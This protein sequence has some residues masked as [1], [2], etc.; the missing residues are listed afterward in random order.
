[1]T[2]LTI[3]RTELIQ[4]AS[5][6]GIK[7]PRTIPGQR[8]PLNP[9]GRMM[10]RFER[11]GAS[12]IG[13]ALERLRRSLFRGLTDG[14]VHELVN[15]LN[16]SQ[17]TQPFQDA[18]M[19]LVEEWALAGANF[20]QAVVNNQILGVTS[21]TKQTTGIDWDLVNDEAAEWAMRYAALLVTDI[22]G[23][24]R[25]R[26]Q[27]EVAAFILTSETIGELSRRIQAS[28]I[29]GESRADMIA[30]TEVTQAF[31]QGNMIAWLG[32]GVVQRRRWNTNNDEL[33][34]P[35]CGPLNQQVAELGQPFE[36]GI[37]NPPAHPRCRCWITPVVI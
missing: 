12:A 8:N 20:G 11:Q 16:D 2:E 3:L 31:A 21:R 7:A 4:A 6:I 29:F 14:T 13:T 17:F 9:D 32:S 33:V 34:C 5:Q 28:G 22:L 24:T 35:V 15:R 26:I 27:R 37:D 30:V 19:Q 36:G 25:Q 18:M 10:R 23:T 1:M